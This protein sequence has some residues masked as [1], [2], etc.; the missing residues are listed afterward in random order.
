MPLG[1]LPLGG[2]FRHPFVCPLSSR[3][4]GLAA[5]DPDS[6]PIG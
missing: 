4:S 5:E 1:K 3:F 2:T 6:A